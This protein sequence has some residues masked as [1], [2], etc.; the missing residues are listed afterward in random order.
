MINI[1]KI[2][3]NLTFFLKLNFIFL[4]ILNLIFINKIF[5]LKDY[6]IKK[7]TN[8]KTHEELIQNV[9]E[10]IDFINN[11]KKEIKMQNNIEEEKKDY[12]KIF[13][14]Q[15]ELIDFLDEIV[16]KNRYIIYVLNG[17]KSVKVEKK[18]KVKIFQTCSCLTCEKILKIE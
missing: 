2:N 1:K 10:E 8:K 7:N 4:F 13:E 9:Q 3:K 15:K 12:K 17:Y 16:K 18:N 6:D 5:A 11:L 14:L